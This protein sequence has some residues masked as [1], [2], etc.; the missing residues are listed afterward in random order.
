[1]FE[2]GLAMFAGIVMVFTAALAPLLLYL[3]FIF[4]YLVIDL[5]RSILRIGK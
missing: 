5:L 3:G 1:M 4:N 2:S